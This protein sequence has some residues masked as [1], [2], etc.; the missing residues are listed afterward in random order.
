MDSGYWTRALTQRVARRRALTAGGGLAIGAALLAACGGSGSSGGNTPDKSRLV[1]KPVDTSGQ[2]VRGGIWPQV[3][4]SDAPS[5]DPM[6]AGRRPFEEASHVYSRLLR[7]KIGTADNPPRGDPEPDAAV[8]WEMSADQTQLTL[9]LRPNMKFDARPPTNGRVLN[10]ND[11]KFSWERFTKISPSRTD[12]SNALNPDAPIV[13]VQAPDATTVVIKVAAPYAPLLKMLAYFRW[14]SILPVEAD[15]GF[16]PRRDMRGSGP[17]LLNKYEPGVVFEYRKNPNFYDIANRPFLDGKDR[18]VV[19]EYATALSQ[20]KAGG[21]WSYSSGPGT[22]N[23]LVRA[24]DAVATKRQVPRLMMLANDILDT[25]RKQLVLGFSGRDN[26]P[27]R[28]E[29]VRHAVS[30]LLDRDAWID[31]FFNVSGLAKD[32]LTVSQ[33]WESTTPSGFQL[34]WLDPKEGKLAEGSKYFRHD[35]VEAK[36]LL[37]AAGKF[38]VE[39]DYTYYPSGGTAG[40]GGSVAR[41]MEVSRDM[42]ASGG[43][44]K[45][46]VNVVDNATVFVSKYQNGKGDFDGISFLNSGSYPDIDAWLSSVYT[47]PGRDAWV[48]NPL[49][50]VQEMILRQRR[51]FDE[52]KRIAMIRDM[53][54]ELALQQPAVAFPG[55]A[56]G[57]DLASPILGNYGYYQAWEPVQSGAA[58]LDTLIWYDKSKQPA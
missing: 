13:S 22:G 8:S 47:V 2:A 20:L 16:D 4:T 15:G 27:L 1:T 24:E 19:P 53:Q 41:N 39:L 34:Y 11:V 43:H 40:R 37:D 38:G 17:W 14:I 28:D 57:F 52:Q 56:Q 23:T 10:A 3:V 50:K 29:R 9:K 7:Y 21:I 45:L 58:E 44:F 12:A 33:R 46:K 51:E 36:K 26:S 6:G 42:L 5:L 18:Y 49:P 35:P 48:K 54:K 30:L 31:A 32:G 25:D 55:I